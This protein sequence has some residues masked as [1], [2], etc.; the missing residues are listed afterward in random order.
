MAGGVPENQR[1][2]QRVSARSRIKFI[3]PVFEGTSQ[4]QPMKFIR[5]LR[6]Y[7]DVTE[8]DGN[9]LCYIISQALKG[10]AGEWWQV[11]QDE[12]DGWDLFEEKFSARFWSEARQNEV[13][14]R[15]QFGFFTGQHGMNRGQYSMHIMGQAKDL[16]IHMTEAE[17]IRQLRNHFS[18][19]MRTAI[20]SQGINT[21]EQLFEFLEAFDTAGVVNQER[22]KENWRRE[23]RY[24]DEKR[25]T[26]RRWEQRDNI[27]REYAAGSRE[28]QQGNR[29]NHMDKKEGGWRKWNEKP[30]DIH[31]SGNKRMTNQV[32][33]IQLQDEESEI[34][35]EKKLESGNE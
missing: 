6:T 27:P 19:E 22:A 35:N 34:S 15:L 2:S 25:D 1:T 33:M 31:T 14:E 7:C 8:A 16:S 10:S 17:I 30:Q 26:H 29:S 18:K 13:R 20:L 4:E 12:I 28:E 24:F 5:D 23:G 9:E 32:N 21:K 3:A 11:V